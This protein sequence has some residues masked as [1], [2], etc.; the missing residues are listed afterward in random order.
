MAEDAVN[1]AVESLSIFDSEADF[2]RELAK[3]LITRNA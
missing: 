1:N 3:T 2:F